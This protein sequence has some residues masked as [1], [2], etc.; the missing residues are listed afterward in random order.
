MIT[1]NNLAQ[2]KKKLEDC[3][4]EFKNISSTTIKFLEIIHKDNN[5]ISN[6]K[7]MQRLE[8][9]FNEWSKYIESI[10]GLRG[11]FCDSAERGIEA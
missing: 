5:K 8:M 2:F 9:L 1:N 4:K 7:K 11:N 6:D 10:D 3:K